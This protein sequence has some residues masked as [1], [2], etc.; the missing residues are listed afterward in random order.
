MHIEK[1]NQPLG[2]GSICIKCFLQHKRQISQ[3]TGQFWAFKKII[4]YWNLFYLRHSVWSDP[5]TKCNLIW[6]HFDW[7]IHSMR[8]E[9][10][11]SFWQVFVVVVMHA[12]THAFFGRRKFLIF[13]D[14]KTNEESSKCVLFCLNILHND[15][16]ELK[17]NTFGTRVWILS[18]THHIIE[19]IGCNF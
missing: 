2:T 4:I 8:L 3:W 10:V 17:T 11:H 1:I 18:T 12:R 7:T 9:F 15:F 14:E 5:I 19:F 13:F 6:L 16:P